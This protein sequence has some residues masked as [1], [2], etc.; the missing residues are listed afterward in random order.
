MAPVDENGE[1]NVGPLRLPKKPLV[2]GLSNI[3]AGLRRLEEE[4]LDEELDVL[5]EIEMEEEG[6]ATKKISPLV[7]KP[8]SGCEKAEVG[9]SQA[10]AVTSK[11]EKPVLLGGFDEEDLYDSSDEEQLERGRPLRKFKKK[12]QKRTTRLANLKPIRAKQPSAS[13]N[14]AAG[15]DNEVVPETQINTTNIAG[16]SEDNL[17]PPM[18]GSDFDCGTSSDDDG[19]ASR[20]GAQKLPRNRNSAAAKARKSKDEGKEEAPGMVKKAVRKVKAT[21]H[22]NF[23][24]LK[25]RNTGSKGGLAHNSRFKRRR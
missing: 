7:T 22:A 6:I 2:R 17:E 25:L 14:R 21:A 20:K 24:R 5:R 15:S 9:D 18:S 13:A 10:V 8:A 16:R 11:P 23:K 3:V 19:G 1:W 4:A 12:G